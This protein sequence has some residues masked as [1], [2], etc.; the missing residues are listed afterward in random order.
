MWKGISLEITFVQ[1]GTFFFLFTLYVPHQLKTKFS[2]DSFIL[3]VRGEIIKVYFYYFIWSDFIEGRWRRRVSITPMPCIKAG[4]A[5][6]PKSCSVEGVAQQQFGFIREFSKSRDQCSPKRMSYCCSASTGDGWL[7]SW[8][9][10]DRGTCVL[11]NST[12]QVSSALI[13]YLLSHGHVLGT[14]DTNMKIQLLLGGTHNGEKQLQLPT[15]IKL[16]LVFQALN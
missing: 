12:H 10:W 6:S 5:A 11:L 7:V 1:L 15:L 9:H 16:L 13:K 8:S 2:K 3:Y 14:E 4:Q